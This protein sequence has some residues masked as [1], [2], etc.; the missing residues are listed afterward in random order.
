MNKVEKY[1]SLQNKVTA[2]LVLHNEKEYSAICE[3]RKRIKE[4]MT[5]EELES[6]EKYV[7]KREFYMGIK[8]YIEKKKAQQSENPLYEGKGEEE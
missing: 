8:P 2:E 6:L 4:E 1:L 5:I 7:T 3:A